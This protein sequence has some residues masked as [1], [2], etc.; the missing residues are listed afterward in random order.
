MKKSILKKLL[1]HTMY[2]KTYNVYLENDKLIANSN[3]YGYYNDNKSVND[4]DFLSLI[5]N[6]E[7]YDDIN[8]IYFDNEFLVLVFFNK[9][10]ITK[11]IFD[12]RNFELDN[13]VIEKIN[14]FKETV[15]NKNDFNLSKYIPYLFNSLNMENCSLINKDET[16]DIKNYCNNIYEKYCANNYINTEFVLIK[17]PVLFG[18]MAFSL[19]INL[20]FRYY[21]D[22]DLTSIILFQMIKIYYTGFFSIKLYD[23]LTYNSYHL[24]HYIDLCRKVQEGDTILIEELTE[25]LATEFYKRDIADYGVNSSQIDNEDNTSLKS[26][27]ELGLFR[28]LTI[29]NSIDSQANATKILNLL[30]L[31]YEYLMYQSNTTD[32]DSIVEDL[33]RKRLNDIEKTIVFALEIDNILSKS[34]A[35]L[36]KANTIDVGNQKVLTPIL[37]R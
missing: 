14:F 28:D 25:T 3:K 8:T 16:D 32:N 1:K 18:Y 5:S 9:P 27:F 17:H 15:T 23:F 10:S 11:C 12:L 24:D 29:L 19:F 7:T 33:F 4:G 35:D 30:N 2:I 21:L 31:G 22:E 34:D 36:I 26:S 20:Y 6:L 37:H 13:E